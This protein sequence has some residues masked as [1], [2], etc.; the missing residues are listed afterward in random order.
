MKYED[1]ARVIEGVLF[2]AGDGVEIDEFK[3]KFDIND[4]EFNKCLDLLKAK[5]NEQSGIN[6]ITY[7]TKVQLCSN[8][9]IVE[10]I[11]EILNPIRE[12]T[13]TKAALETVAII[14][15]KQPITRLEIENIRNVKN[16]DYA[17]DLLI[18]NNLIEVVG[19]KD[20]V[21]K[22]LLYGTTDQFLKRF[23]LS[24]IESL[25]NYNELLDRIRVIHSEGDSLYREFSI[26]D[27]ENENNDTA[28]DKSQNDNKVAN[29][30]D[31]SSNSAKSEASAAD[32]SN[33]NQAENQTA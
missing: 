4:K 18:S 32:L 25:P 30:A 22:P 31:I 5:Y 6:I 28:A 21:G 10:D 29:N 8:P 20:A 7:K 12:R 33:T 27:E 9:Q 16:A 2:V 1:I 26:P 24:S 3:R 23:G 19:R 14:A 15:Y 11:S 13:L 17:I